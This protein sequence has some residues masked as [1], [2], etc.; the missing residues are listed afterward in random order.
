MIT[1][2][3]VGRLWILTS[4]LVLLVSA[5]MRAQTQPQAK[6]PS[7]SFKVDVVVSRS[8]AGKEV[9]RLPFSLWV[10]VTG[11]HGYSSI[12]MGVDVPVGKVTQTTTSTNTSTTTTGDNYRSVGTSIDAY[13]DRIEDGKYSVKVNLQDSSI[14]SPEPDGKIT[15]NT[16]DPKAYRTMAIQNTSQMRDGQ[17]MPFGIATDRV[18]GETVRMD[19]TLTIVK[20]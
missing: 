2:T 5:G 19:V 16:A 6:P 12:R 9:S 10:L 18:S 1:K 14:F 7:A 8:L 11:E 3:A 20:P 4:A 17:T 15:V 13:V